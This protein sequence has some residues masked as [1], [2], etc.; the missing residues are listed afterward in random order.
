MCRSDFG[1]CYKSYQFR[2]MLLIKQLPLFT[3]HQLQISNHMSKG[4]GKDVHIPFHIPMIFSLASHTFCGCGTYRITRIIRS[5]D[6]SYN[7]T[8]HGRL[9]FRLIYTVL[10]ASQDFIS[11]SATV[12]T[13]VFTSQTS[14]LHFFSAI[15][16]QPSLNEQERKTC[17]GGGLNQDLLSKPLNNHPS[18]L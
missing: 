8:R 2:E 17:K 9:S 4:K 18:P 7:E 12:A 11:Q 14:G 10:G 15:T 16:G 13:L 1:I 5:H 6:L 3:I